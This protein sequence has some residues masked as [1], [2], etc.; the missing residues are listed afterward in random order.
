[1]KNKF[2]ESCRASIG[3]DEA[4]VRAVAVDLS[5]EFYNTSMSGFWNS[6]HRVPGRRVLT[7]SHGRPSPRPPRS[8][9]PPCPIQV[10]EGVLISAQ[11]PAHQPDCALPRASAG[12]LRRHATGLRL[13]SDSHRMGTQSGLR[14]AACCLGPLHGARGGGEGRRGEGW[15][16]E[17]SVAHRGSAA[18]LC[19]TWRAC[20][21]PLSIP[22]PTSGEGW[23]DPPAHRLRH[24]R[25]RQPG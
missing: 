12:S 11:V 22:I 9:L 5:S 13:V 18:S 17:G 4:R 15:G 1:M 8:A 23:P 6:S 10:R 25:T 16:G 7:S 2:C 14:S 19:L 21:S 20:A 24:P 3:V